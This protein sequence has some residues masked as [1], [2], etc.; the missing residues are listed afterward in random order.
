M[1]AGGAGLAGVV[2][3]L[4]GA[5]VAGAPT[6]PFGGCCTNGAGPVPPPPLHD[7]SAAASNAAP[8]SERSQS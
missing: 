3:W 6:D 1:T 8:A 2:G 5:L 4:V 7:A